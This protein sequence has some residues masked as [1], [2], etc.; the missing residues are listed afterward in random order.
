MRDR[1]LMAWLLCLGLILWIG[2]LPALL[3]IWATEFVLRLSRK[4]A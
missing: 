2:E 4:V 1:T 3:L